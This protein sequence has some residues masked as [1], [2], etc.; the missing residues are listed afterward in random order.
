MTDHASIIQTLQSYNECHLYLTI[1]LAKHPIEAME[2]N[3]LAAALL[4][5]TQT[6]NYQKL[7]HNADKIFDTNNICEVIKMAE[8]EK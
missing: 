1:E 3:R 2:K 5:L 8:N 6:K 7:Q 4:F